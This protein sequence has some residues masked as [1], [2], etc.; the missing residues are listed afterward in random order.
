MGAVGRP[1][2]KSFLNTELSSDPRNGAVGRPVLEFS[3]H[4]IPG[5]PRNGA[6]RAV[7]SLP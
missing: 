1:V 3:T 4:E 7:F 5:N 2:L 6:G